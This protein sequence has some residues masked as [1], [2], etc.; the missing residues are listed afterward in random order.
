[1]RITLYLCC[2]LF[3]SAHD[4]PVAFFKIYKSE[5]KVLLEIVL[6][7]EDLSNELKTTKKIDINLIQDYLEQHTRFEFDSCPTKV[8]V[9]KLNYEKGHIKL[10]CFFEGISNYYSTFL[11][12]NN[13]ML[14]VNNYSNIIKIEINSLVG[15][16]N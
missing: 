5:K 12:E 9:Q 8:I 6:D 11:I 10:F 2:L 16:I 1:M 4:T 13:C 15:I 3:I 14:S 7:A